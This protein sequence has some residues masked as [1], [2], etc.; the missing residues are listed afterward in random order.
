MYKGFKIRPINKMAEVIKK[1]RLSK[2]ERLLKG[3]LL[4]FDDNNKPKD[5]AE[6]IYK[7]FNKDFYH[8]ENNILTYTVSTGRK[9]GNFN[10]RSIEDLFRL[11]KHYIPKI[12]YDTIEDI[13]K[14]NL[15]TVCLTGWHCTT[16]GRHVYKFR[17]STTAINVNTVRNFLK[18]NNIEIK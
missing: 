9:S 1:K 11:C 7:Y 8:P 14:S 2:E 10:S 12:S 16:C 15:D 6:L 18:N 3:A 4:K 5:L 13:I 17:Y